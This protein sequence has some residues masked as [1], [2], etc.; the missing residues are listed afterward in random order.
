VKSSKK[1]K[2]SETTFLIKKKN[3]KEKVQHEKL[4]HHQK[5]KHLEN[6]GDKKMTKLAIKFIYLFV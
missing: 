6:S 2:K 4:G 1:V 3:T 5:Q